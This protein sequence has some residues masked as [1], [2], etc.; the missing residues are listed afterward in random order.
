VALPNAGDLL[1]GRFRL[2]GVLGSGG[3]GVVWAAHDEQLGQRVAIKLIFPHLLTELARARLR[4]EVNAARQPHPH[5]VTVYDLHEADGLA[6]LSMELVEGPTLRQHLLDRGHLDPAEVIEIGRQVA[7][8][9]AHLHAA[10]LVH[11]DVKP[12]N[13][14]LS[15][16]GGGVTWSNL[17]VPG[18]GVRGPESGPPH[19]ADDSRAGDAAVVKLCDLGL[20]RPLAPGSTLTESAMV[21]GTPAYM[22]PEQ[23]L[24]ADLTGRT[25][26][27]ALGITL[28]ECLTGQIPL[29][30]ES[31]VATLVRRQKTRVPRVRA[32][33]PSC[34]V[35]L[36]RLL[37]RMLDPDPRQRPNAT[38]VE[39][40]L[41]SGHLRF[42]FPVK[43]LVTLA[44]TAALVAAGWIGW[45]WFRIPRTVRVDVVGHEVRGVDDRG[46]TTWTY[47]PAAPIRQVENADLDGDGRAETIVAS[48]VEDSNWEFTPAP[49]RVTIL[50]NEGRILDSK[51]PNDVVSRWPYAFSKHLVALFKLA[52]LDGDG[53][54]EVLVQC[55]H[56]TYYPSALLV[57]WPGVRRWE[58]ALVHS[59]HLQDVTVVPGSRPSRLVFTA[60]NN[61]LGMVSVVGELTIEQLGQAGRAK[62][63]IAGASLQSPD[64]SC[65]DLAWVGWSW[66]LPFGSD[67]TLDS[68]LALPDGT[69]EVRWANA[70]YRIDAAGNPLFGPNARRDLAVERKLFLRELGLLQPTKRELGGGS[71]IELHHRIRKECGVLLA[72][73]A[74]SQVL[75]LATARALA[76][77]GDFG[78]ATR[79]LEDERGRPLNQDIELQLVQF[80]AIRGDISRAVAVLMEL[81]A[82]DLRSRLFD[83]ARSLLVVGIEGHDS[84][85][86]DS[87]IRWLVH[88]TASTPRNPDLESAL[89]VRVDLWWN[90]IADA[91]L[92]VRSSSFAPEGAALACLARWRRGLAV[93]ED[94]VEMANLQRQWP[95]ARTEAQLASA[96]VLL[97]LG[98]DKEAGHLLDEIVD[99]L[100]WSARLQF[101]QKQLLDLALSMRAEA[102]RHT[103]GV[104]MNRDDC[105]HLRTFSPGLLPSV[106][107]AAACS[108]Q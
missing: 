44:A 72:E 37:D 16:A 62:A 21:V 45:D 89:R 9:L 29:Q 92:R 7:S 91:D 67:A 3:S 17:N 58:V 22:A 32:T 95:D 55:R 28:Y 25:D 86:V 94:L 20:V 4:R 39:R 43:Q 52:D 48:F 35:L 10:G 2:L 70:P 81:S 80:Y 63:M 93:P 64:L 38:E 88:P 11:R 108:Q 27:Y 51:D 1:T 26:V 105:L 77:E 31:A 46:R 102:T 15:R 24:G 78:G 90:Q 106:V 36:D 23:G 79:L 53:R 60:L 74:Y 75:A 97:G 34:P 6:F 41:A 87:A 68:L 65:E 54:P 76:R 30:G 85:A 56:T 61:P 57:F 59:G 100:A 18:S 104:A 96:A 50:N 14:L 40:T 42:R 5:F 13:V 101:D 47:A 103:G 49:S 19:L 82:R 33:C 12:G 99:S 8:A 73:P 107:A 71:V 84:D 69:I 83:T 66:Y 98:R